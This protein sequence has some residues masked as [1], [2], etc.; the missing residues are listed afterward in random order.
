[1]N[2]LTKRILT[3]AVLFAVVVVWMF[4]LPDSWFDRVA[5]VV[6]LVMSTELL[7]MVA[8]RRI[9]LYAIVAAFAWAM[10]LVLWLFL[11]PG[12]G[13]VAAILFCS[14][15][16]ILVFFQHADERILKDDFKNIAYAQWMMTLLLVFVWSVMLI[17][18]QENGVWFLAGAMAG[19]WCADIAAY[20]A[21]R[22]FG[23]K[24]LCPAVSPGK[25]KEG[26]YGA[27]LFGCAGASAIWILLAGVAPLVAVPLSLLLVVV[28]IAGDLAE[29]ALKRAVGVKDSGNILPGHG[30]ILDRV[31]A[32][33][34]AVPVVG[35]IWMGLA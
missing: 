4:Y 21:G 7:V 15:M 33:I 5:V 24:K 11:P 3:A 16:W 32:L 29:S 25:T 10:L 14:M 13:P 31:D 2:E 28:A 17:H 19:V 12:I 18:R 34:P 35:L 27:L 9:I 6:G 1:M 30:G 23:S 26:C 20:F 22:A 8:V